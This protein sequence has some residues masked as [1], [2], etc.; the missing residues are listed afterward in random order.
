MSDDDLSDVGIHLQPKNIAETADIQGA[1]V[2]S[3]TTC[4]GSTLDKWFSYETDILDL[5]AV[6]FLLTAGLCFCS[7]QFGSLKYNTHSTYGRRN[8]FLITNPTRRQFILVKLKQ[9]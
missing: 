5:L 2:K 9:S 1:M 7:F 3:L 8:L 6:I 4:S